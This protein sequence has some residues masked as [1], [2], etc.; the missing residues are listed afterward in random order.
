MFL[1][2]SSGGSWEGG[3]CGVWIGRGRGVIKHMVLLFLPWLLKADLL[4]ALCHLPDDLTFL[5]SCP[6]S[7]TFGEM[8]PRLRMLSHSFPVKSLEV[9]FLYFGLTGS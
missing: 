8:Q 6:Y 2:G 5:S 9:F 1:N 7:K 3:L 4:T